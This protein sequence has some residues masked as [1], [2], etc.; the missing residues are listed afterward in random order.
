VIRTEGV[1]Y[2]IEASFCDKNL[3]K[4]VEKIKEIL[5][6]AAQKARMTIKGSYFY[7]FN[8]GVSGIVIVA[9]SHL[10]IHTWPEE[11]YAAIDIYTCG[12]SYP[13][14]AVDFILREIKCKKAHI[15]KIDRGI[16]SENSYLHFITS[17]EK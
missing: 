9:Q 11:A 13:E 5:T 14:I 6:K 1:H 16:K 12:D 17:Y 10:S 4:D 7:D 3:L 2:I 15:T 8:G